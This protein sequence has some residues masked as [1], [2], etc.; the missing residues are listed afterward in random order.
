MTSKADDRR[1]RSRE[2][3]PD[4]P[5][6]E[7]PPRG[8]RREVFKGDCGQIFKKAVG[9]AWTRGEALALT[10]VERVEVRYEAERQLS[11]K[12]SSLDAKHLRH[13]DDRAVATACPRALKEGDV[14]KA[15]SH[16]AEDWV[17]AL[18][19]GFQ[20][21]RI[22]VEYTAIRQTYRKTMDPHSDYLILTSGEA[23]P[24]CNVMNP[25]EVLAA[26]RHVKI[27]F[28]GRGEWHGAPEALRKFGGLHL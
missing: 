1:G 6:S 21:D 7:S 13:L 27:R 8:G 10:Q 16:S 4:G 26:L 5:G 24:E 12:S 23:D 20:G 17:D 22:V 15:Y 18:L 14:V 28:G 25:D 2:A 9:G 19:V 11:S 3:S